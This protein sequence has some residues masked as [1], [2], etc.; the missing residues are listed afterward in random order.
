MNG[1]YGSRETVLDVPEYSA[2]KVDVVFH[3]T[4]SSV[5][6]PALFVVVTNNVFVVGIGMLGEISLNEITCFIS[7]EAEEDVELIY[8]ARVETDRMGS[9]CG[10]ILE[11]EEIIWHAWRT[12]HLTSSVETKNEEIKHEPV[13]LDDERRELETT[14]NTVVVGV[15][16]IL[17]GEL[18]VVLGS[19][20]IGDVV[21]DN[22]SKK[23]IQQ[24]HIDLLIH[25]VELCL[26]ENV[27]LALTS[28]PNFLEVVDTLA[29][30]VNK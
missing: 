26:D 4:H 7:C 18:D 13:V 14:E 21:I 5:S 23:P 25:L 1:G 29:P 8:V 27:A 30:L 6:R 28:L 16:H 17:V 20:V 10:H 9:F 15:V 24:E 3:Q 22:Q 19:D 11:T 2:S 12:S